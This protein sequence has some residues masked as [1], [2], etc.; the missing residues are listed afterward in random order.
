MCAWRP[1]AVGCYRTAHCVSLCEP[2][3][4][5]AP[6]TRRPLTS[7]RQAHTWATTRSYG[8]ETR[9]MS[10]AAADRVRMAARRSYTV[11]STPAH[12]NVI[13]KAATIR[14]MS[15]TI[16][17]PS[18]RAY[19]VCVQS[20]SPKARLQLYIGGPLKKRLST[21]MRQFVTCVHRAAMDNT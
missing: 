3:D 2:H 18:L 15:M 21:G 16:T 7:V 14:C 11:R 17:W 6:A 9:R 13:K 4:A 20:T 5:L 12:T 8:H 10:A 19:L 1:L